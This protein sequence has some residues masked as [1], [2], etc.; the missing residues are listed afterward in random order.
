MTVVDPCL[1]LP[2]QLTVEAKHYRLIVKQGDER[3]GIVGFSTGNG[4]H[5]FSFPLTSESRL[6]IQYLSGAIAVQ[7]CISKL[8]VQQG[9]TFLL[10]VRFLQ[11]FNHPISR[12]TRSAKN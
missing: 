4:N 7:E 6:A 11:H 10:G 5:S 8:D 12:G 1:S 3:T 2:S 9:M